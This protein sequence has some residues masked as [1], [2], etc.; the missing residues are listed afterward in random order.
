MKSDLL[1]L[2]TGQTREI[3]TRVFACFSKTDEHERKRQ[4][5]FAHRSKSYDYCNLYHGK[6]VVKVSTAVVS[7]CLGNSVFLVH[8]SAS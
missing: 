6:P 1:A 4:S 2:R 5:T 7:Q 3:L 8:E